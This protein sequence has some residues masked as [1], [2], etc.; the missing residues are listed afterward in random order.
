MCLW[1]LGLLPDSPRQQNSESVRAHPQSPRTPLT[2]DWTVVAAVAELL[3]AAGVIF[4]LLYLGRQIKL[5]AQSERRARYDTLIRE[6]I[7]WNR[8]VA[9]QQDLAGIVFR[10]AADPASLDPEESFRFYLMLHPIFRTFESLILYGL[11][12]EVHDWGPESFRR[13]MADFVGMP[14][15]RAYWAGRKHWF[16]PRAQAEIDRMIAE[17]SG[18]AVVESLAVAAG[19]GGEGGV[20]PPR[21]GAL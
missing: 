3:G 10:G 8:N 11:E 18:D 13:A 20:S 17:S 6:A 2:V 1:V 7:A 16:A 15:V 4:S 21:G 9:T 12:G 14:G 19:L 5:S